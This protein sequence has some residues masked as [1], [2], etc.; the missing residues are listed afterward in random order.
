[1]RVLIKDDPYRG[2]NPDAKNAQRGQWPCKWVAYADAAAPPFVTAY[3]LHFE[4]PQEATVRV[5]VSADERYEL[6]LDGE[7]IARGS[8]RGDADNWFFETYDIPLSAGAHR[9]VARVWSMGDEE[10]AG[11]PYAQMSVYPGFLFSPQ[12]EEWIRVLGT[13]VAPWEARLLGGYEFRKPITNWG[14]GY[15]LRIDGAKFSWGLSAAKATAGSRW[16]SAIPDATRK[17]ATI[18]KLFI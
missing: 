9:L 10:G 16:W 5:H 13:G 6:F 2:C 17:I 1:M 12:D 18:S 15:N 4:A 11:A 14:T 8:E 7:R 3:R